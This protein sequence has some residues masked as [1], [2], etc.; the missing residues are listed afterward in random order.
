MEIRVL[1]PVEVELGGR[2]LRLGGPKQR[3]VLS[4]LALNANLTVSIDR[5]IDGLWENAQPASAAKM[6]QLYVS[7]LR[8]LL[9]EDGGCEIVTHGRGY[10]LRLDPEAVDAARFERL[11]AE[12]SGVH[13]PRRAPTARPRGPQ[14]EVR[15]SEVPSGRPERAVSALERALSL[16]R[17]A[18]LADLVDEPFAGRE[19]ARLDDLRLRARAAGRGRSCA[20]PPRRADR[21]ARGA[22]RRAPLSRAAPCAAD[23]CSVSVRPAGGRAAGLPGRAQDAD[24]G[25]GDRAQPASAGPRA[26]DPRAGSACSRHRRWSRRAAAEPAANAADAHHRARRG[27]RRR[28]AAAPPSRRSPCDSDRPGRRGKDAARAR[29]GARARGRAPRRRLARLA[30]RHRKGRARPERDRAGARRHTVA[31]RGPQGGRRTLPCPQARVADA[32]QLRAPPIGGAPCERSPGRLCGADGAG[33]KSRG[34]ATA[35]RAPLC[36]GT[37]AGPRGR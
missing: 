16:W 35:G 27:P 5:L 33:D 25:S 30:R 37:A 10:E 13:V 1:G 28:G 6:V 12:A 14:A 32:R 34:A 19:I 15:A 7:Q 18:P 24:R 23:A 20:R 29:G 3:A 4:L 36:G 22:G 11:I 8:K 26:R 21:R 2:R 9:G 31:G 17:G